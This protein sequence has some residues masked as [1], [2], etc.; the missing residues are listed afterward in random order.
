MSSDKPLT[1]I[2]DQKTD[3]D[4]RSPTSF[5]GTNKTKQAKAVGDVNI[6]NETKDSLIQ[7]VI[8]LD[9]HQ[10]YLHKNGNT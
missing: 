6:T 7:K 1:V 3:I 4:L 9:I 5:K 2:H 10:F 8:L